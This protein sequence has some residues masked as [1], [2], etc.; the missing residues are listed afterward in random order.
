[1][2]TLRLHRVD[3]TDWG[4]YH[5][6]WFKKFGEYLSKYFNIEWIDYAKHSSQ[7]SAE[8]NLLTEVPSFGYNPPISDVD[9]IIENCDT[10]EFVILTFSE[11]FTSYMV[12]SFRSPYC[13]NALLAHFGYQS[14]YYWLKK[15]NL[16]DKLS[17]IKP[18]FFGS[19]KEYDINKYRQTR[20]NNL[21][22]NNKIFWKG[23]GT[24]YF[25]GHPIYRETIKYIGD[26]ITDT[27]YSFDFDQYMLQ[28]CIHRIA[29]SFYMD[30]SKESDAFTYPGEFCYRDMEY[31]SIGLPFI[32][33]EYKDTL[34][35]G[36]IPFKHYLS[37]PRE[38]AMKRFIKEGN[39]GVGQLIREKFIEFKDETILLN[40]ISQNQTEWFDN[41]CKWP[42]SA[43]LT[44]QLAEI[45]KWIS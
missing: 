40:Y 6:P 39:S 31:C 8:A 45:D 41:Y 19:Y 38:E 24:G 35:E 4:R 13:K 37:I 14:A 44:L 5:S 27:A 30:L 3:N 7:G 16:L 25:P 20:K 34:H 21:L 11:F 23:L 33:I 1:M 17:Q 10:K 15:E 36:L 18:W 28:M 22:I 29:L 32:R 43:K 26:D 12:H 2:T 9:C 42:N